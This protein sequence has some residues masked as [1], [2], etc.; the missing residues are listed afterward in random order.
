MY[1]GGW[2]F[3]LILSHFLAIDKLYDSIRQTSR[4]F[5]AISRALEPVILEAVW[6][7]Q[8]LSSYPHAP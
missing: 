8:R 5:A 2:G 1:R 3:P 6:F 7:A 4:R